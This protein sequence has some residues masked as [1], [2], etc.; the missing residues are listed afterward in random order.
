M[1]WSCK[2]PELFKFDG[3]PV[4]RL[5]VDRTERTEGKLIRGRE[6][7]SG[8]GDDIDLWNREIVAH[9]GMFMR[10]FHHEGFA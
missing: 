9:E 8:V 4:A 1:I 5:A 10:I 2:H 7:H 6:R 3:R